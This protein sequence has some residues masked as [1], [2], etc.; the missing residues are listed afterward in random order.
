ML[1]AFAGPTTTML[2]KNTALRAQPGADLYCL[3]ILFH[4]TWDSASRLFYFYAA[5]AQYLLLL[6]AASA[7]ER[8]ALPGQPARPGRAGGR[9]TLLQP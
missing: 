1:P 8:H 3:L 2:Q 7:R 6:A 4:S 5:L 9:A